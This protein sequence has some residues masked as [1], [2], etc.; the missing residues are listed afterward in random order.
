M[1][2][3]SLG[4]EPDRIAVVGDDVETDVAGAV[5]AGM[6]GILVRTGKHTEA[7][8]RESGARP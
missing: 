4:V 8:L 3:R 1:G 7:R 5:A 6:T 2:A